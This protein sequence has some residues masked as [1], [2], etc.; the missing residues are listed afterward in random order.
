MPTPD[1]QTLFDHHEGKATDKWQCYLQIYDKVLQERRSGLKSLLEIGI[2]NGGSLEIWA[3]YFESAQIVL[4]CDI[5]EACKELSFE[6]SRIR[7]IIGDANKR[8]TRE[9][10]TSLCPQF[11]LIIDDGSHTSKDIIATVVNF[12]PLLNDD[13]ILIVEDLHCS[14]W[15]GYDGGLHFPYSSVSFL[16][17]LVDIINFEHWG[18]EKDRASHLTAFLRH[19][20][21][22]EKLTALDTIHSI[23]FANSTA[24]IRKRPSSENTLGERR[25]RGKEAKV[26]PE[27][28]KKSP[29]RPAVPAQKLAPDPLDSEEK[30][31][32]SLDQ[33]NKNLEGAQTEL[34]AKNKAY[35]AMAKQLADTKEQLE[36]VLDSLQATNTHLHRIQNSRIWRYTSFIR[37]LGKLRDPKN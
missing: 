33:A 30:L 12:L 13:G 3:K 26:I 7:T 19:Y 10:I 9:K 21:I 32:A 29:E 27:I 16:T 2:Q 24:I 23:E 8:D 15:N 34:A 36:T 31:A 18:L 11:D 5:N 22:D 37:K 28:L 25:I 14:Y 4:G 17:R 20:E 1:L 6:D 35:N